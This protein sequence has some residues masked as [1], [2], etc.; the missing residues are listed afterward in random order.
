MRRVRVLE[1]EILND[2]E[3]LQMQQEHCANDLKVI[4]GEQE[5][6]REKIDSKTAAEREEKVAWEEKV[7]GVDEEIRVLM[8]QLAEKQKERDIMVAEVQKIDGAIEAVYSKYSVRVDELEVRHKES[9]AKSERLDMRA[10]N[11]AK[12]KLDAQ[13]DRERF[14]NDFA[15]MEQQ[16]ADVRSDL[17]AVII[18]CERLVE[19]RTRRNAAKNGSADEETK[20]ISRL[21]DAVHV[22][23][24]AIG[25]LET[26]IAE[27]ESE[28][29]ER[30]S[31]ISDIDDKQ[32]PVLTKQKKQAVAARNFK[33]AG[34]VAGLVKGL[35]AKKESVEKELR[36]FEE[37]MNAAYA[38]KA[39]KEDDCEKQAAELEGLEKEHD[40]KALHEANQVRVE[41]RRRVRKVRKQGHFNENERAHIF[42]RGSRPTYQEMALY[43]ERQNS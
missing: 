41:L 19:E 33:E 16:E 25:V 23:R 39:S 31:A 32:V 43:N 10:S 8:E 34:R 29:R 9:V 28:A 38:E 15:T 21:R 7:S 37:A 36:E 14:E 40:M 35:L 17:E 18:W 5:K 6:I 27:I 22:G 12:R 3:R 42:S 2:E 13:A 24:Q 20:G 26:K 30:R 1:K 11:L 4:V